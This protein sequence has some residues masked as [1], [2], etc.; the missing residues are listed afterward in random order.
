MA[1]LNGQARHMHWDAT[2]RFCKRFYE[3]WEWLKRI[4][5]GTKKVLSPEAPARAGEQQM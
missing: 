2:N 1:R 4:R 3:Q 5:Y